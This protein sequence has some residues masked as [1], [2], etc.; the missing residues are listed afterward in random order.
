MT[1]EERTLIQTA[2]RRIDAAAAGSGQPLDAEADR[3]MR[4]A[5]P[6]QPAA[7]YLAVQALL[8][9]DHAL[10]QAQ[11]RIEQLEADLAR[12]RSTAAAAATAPASGSTSFL[13][14]ALRD[15]PW[16]AGQA[17]APPFP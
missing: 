9:Q 14:A 3:L 10:R 5:F 2:L 15:G 7:P 16:G 11:A 12:S 8:V 17:V 6:R 13:G 4:E 1:P